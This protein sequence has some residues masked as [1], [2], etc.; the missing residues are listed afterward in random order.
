MRLAKTECLMRLMNLNSSMYEEICDWLVYNKFTTKLDVNQNTREKEKAELIYNS[1]R[2]AEKE[3]R[4]QLIS[5][6]W[7]ILPLEQIKIICITMTEQ[8]EF[9]HGY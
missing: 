3:E 8:K 5:Y 4:L 2:T 9:S 1:L 7:Q 6:E